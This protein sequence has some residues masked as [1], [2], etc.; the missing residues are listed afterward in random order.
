MAKFNR[1]FRG[2]AG[3][4]HLHTHHIPT[5]DVL[6]FHMTPG[7]KPFVCGGGV[8]VKRIQN[9]GYLAGRLYEGKVHFCFF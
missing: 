4:G 9:F 6:P 8:G 2:N 1:R 5:P 7:F 3:D